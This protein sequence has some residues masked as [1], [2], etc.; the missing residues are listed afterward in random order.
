MTKTIHTTR[1]TP[2]ASSATT[3]FS[4]N[5]FERVLDALQIAISMNRARVPEV[6]GSVEHTLRQAM[7]VQSLCR[8]EV[9]IEQFER[10]HKGADSAKAL[11]QAVACLQQIT[12]PEDYDLATLMEPVYGLVAVRNALPPR[13]CE[14]GLMKQALPLFQ[15]FARSLAVPSQDTC[16]AA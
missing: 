1:I 5:A 11:C 9:A 16:D 10:V 6:I 4:C 14:A 12:Q 7:W 15:Q 2:N 13:S 8:L 3:V